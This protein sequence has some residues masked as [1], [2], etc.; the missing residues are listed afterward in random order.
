MP[1]KMKGPPGHSTKQGYACSAFETPNVADYVIVELN[2]DC[3]VAFAAGRFAG[4][5]AGEAQARA[6][7]RV[8]DRYDIA[9]VRS[10]FGMKQ[11]DLRAR[12]ALAGTLPP[13]PKAAVYAKKGLNAS[14]IHSGYA[15][16][17]PKNGGDAAK[18]ADELRRHRSAVWHACVAPR[19]VPAVVGSAAGSR[20]FEPAQGYLYAAPDGIGAAEVWPLKG[21]RGKGVTICDIEGAWNRRHEDLPSGIRLIGGTMRPELDWRNHGTAVLG[22]MISLRN[23]Q[24]TVGICHD[25]KAVVHAAIIDGV[26]NLAGALARATAVLNPGDVI[27]IELQAEERPNGKFLAMQFWDPI[28]TAIVAATA[29]GITVVEAAGNGDVNFDAPAFKDTGLQ[30]DSGA[31]VVGAG[32]PP[33]NHVDF[34]GEDPLPG[35]ASLGAPRSRLYFSNYG[36]IVNVQGWG[37]HVATLGYGDA[38][39]GASENR[40]YT[41]RFSGTSSAAPIVAGAAACLQGRAKAKNGAPMTPAKVRDILMKTGTPQQAG[42]G[43]PLSQHIGPLPNL[44]LAMKRV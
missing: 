20:N 12:V 40:W 19:P 22:E 44:P 18:L 25:A 30:M 43:A 21:A 27:L 34:A 33:S 24:G 36:K 39:G 13:E 28:F 7:N 2:Y 10:H 9:A 35:Y 6:L 11:A 31:I 37:W 1:K 38:Q 8:L 32:V 5:A 16:I 29:K 14:F 41:L 17:V 3:P 15:Q 23:D 4:S 26:F 42:P